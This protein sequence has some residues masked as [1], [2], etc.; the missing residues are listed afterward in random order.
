MHKDRN[1]SPNNHSKG[2]SPLYGV[3]S[4][5]LEEITFNLATQHLTKIEELTAPLHAADMADLITKLDPD[6]RQQYL[7]LI[8][9]RIDPEILTY[10]EDPVREEVFTILGPKRMAN[11]VTSLDTDDA[12]HLIEDLD[13]SQQKA[14]LTQVAAPERAMLEEGLSYPEDSAGRLMQ[15]QLVSVPAFWTVSEVID[16]IRDTQDLPDTFYNIYVV[17]PR[18]H[19]IGVISL[20]T[21]LRQNPTT[22]TGEVMT[23]DLRTIPV[24][25]DQEEVALLFRHYALLSAPVIDAKGRFVGMITVDDVVNVID[26]EAEEDIMHLAGVRESDFNAPIP[27]TSYWRSRW[28]IVTLL[29][30][31]IASSVISQFQESIEEKVALS[32]LMIIVAAMGGNSGM[33]TVTVTVRA[34][35]TRELMTT[36]TWQAIGK[37]LMVGLLNGAVF[38]ITL[39]VIVYLW[40]H[41]LSLSLVL[42]IA[43]L[44]IMLWS[45]LAGI[46]MPIIIQRFGMDPAISAGP[47]LTTTTD[48]LGFSIFL[49]LAT[50]VL[51]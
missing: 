21:L 32:F 26:E 31:L 49:G 15:R 4:G 9:H 42:G 8:K 1:P 6:P 43:I 45:G 41:D 11:A 48:I 27:H 3:S 39:S 29:S 5:L 2:A 35:A 12:I 10:L 24:T 37:E 51:L 14:V 20:D 38:A 50:Y 23:T 25:M 44:C 17:D 22:S 16:F 13:K 19:P 47:M 40:L 7:N 34:L 46:C 30:T 36:N 18:H 33:Q 28:L